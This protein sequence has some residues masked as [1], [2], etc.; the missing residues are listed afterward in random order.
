MED[1]T[2]PA[3]TDDRL[4]GDTLDLV[5]VTPPQQKEKGNQ[6]IEDDDDYD[7]HPIIPGVKDGGGPKL[8]SGTGKLSTLYLFTYKRYR[9]RRDC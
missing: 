6:S 1:D 2:I 5:L 7:K 9:T 4:T 8:P 3:Y